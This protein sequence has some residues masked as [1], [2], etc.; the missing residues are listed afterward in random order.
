VLFIDSERIEFFVKN[1]NILSQLRRSTLGTGPARHSEIETRV[2]DQSI[3]Q[4]IPYRDKIS[5]QN[6]LST[7]TNSY[8]ISTSST[9]TI[10]DGIILNTT[11]PG[12]DQI[13]VYYG[14]RLLRKSP[15]LVQNIEDDTQLLSSPEEFSVDAATQVLTL[16]IREPIV[17]GTM[18]SIVQK[19]GAI[20]TGTESLLTSD[21]MQARF[22]RAK[23]TELPGI[24]YYGGDP[25]I[26]EDSNIALTEEDDDPLEEGF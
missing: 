5:K 23:G 7:N 15:L 14:G 16:N 4:N 17:N 9:L 26:R 20:W 13:S 22:L 24:Y 21:V 6:I 3:R 19:K 2:V 11:L 18:I 1:G 12:K 10:G 8:V 25:T